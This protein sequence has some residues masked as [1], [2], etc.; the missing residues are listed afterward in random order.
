M[1]F[2]ERAEAV[3]DFWFGPDYKSA[4]DAWFPTDR[5]SLW[6]KGGP[7]VD[8][9]VTQTF[10][11]DLE[12]IARG[13]FDSWKDGDMFSIVAG[14]VL[15]DQFSRNAY[16]GTP[17]SFALDPKALEWAELAVESGT[18]K[19]L[20]AV[21]RYFTYMP[22]MHSENLAMQEKGVGLFRSAAEEYAAGGDRTAV[23][24]QAMRNG[25]DF[26]ARHQVIIARWGRFPHRN[27]ILGR[28]TTPEEEAGLA[29]G[30]IA[31]F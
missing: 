17:Q 31:K 2:Y 20:P 4:D 16:R 6:F 15:M 27:A 13:D 21:M 24:A 28:E 19:K 30:S 10:G 26:A 29:D 12:A 22:Y 23:A 18:D 9:D 14:I 25:D 11:R 3:L 5:Y 1:M 8:Q 7:A